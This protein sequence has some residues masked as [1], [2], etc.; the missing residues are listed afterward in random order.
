M[1]LRKAGSKVVGLKPQSDELACCPFILKHLASTSSRFY[2][3][4]FFL[5][6]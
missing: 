3:S 1:E 5:I 6:S 2:F 4:D